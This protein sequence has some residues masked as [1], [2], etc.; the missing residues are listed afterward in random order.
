MSFDLFLLKFS[1]GEG[2]ELPRDAVRL[3]LETC[4]CK[5]RDEHF[6]DITLTDGSRLE[7]QAGGLSG[8]GEFDMCIFRLG[9]SGKNVLNFVLEVVKA[10]GGV[11]IPPSGNPRILSDES[12]RA[13]LPADFAPP[14]TLI[15]IT[16]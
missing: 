7:L 1:K 11:L 8:S 16:E 9:D 15:T 13:E 3:V 12:Q 10:S 5:Q 2:C 6:Y 14:G 4:D